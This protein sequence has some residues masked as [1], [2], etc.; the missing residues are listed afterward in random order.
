MPKAPRSSLS[1]SAL[2]VLFAASCGEQGAEPRSAGASRDRA[3]LEGLWLGEAEIGQ[4]GL[5]V[6]FR[7]GH[8][9][10][11]GEVASLGGVSIDSAPVRLGGE[12]WQSKIT[13][14]E[15]GQ[16]GLSFGLGERRG[17]SLIGFTTEPQLVAFPQVEGGKAETIVV[18]HHA[19]LCVHVRQSAWDEAMP[20]PAV[21]A[22]FGWRLE[23]VPMMD[24]LPLT[25]G[26]TMIM[27]IRFDG[28]GLEGCDCKAWLHGDGTAK[29]REV[30]RGKSG[31]Q[32]IIEL[33]LERHGLWRIVA[34]HRVEGDT[35]RP[36]ELHI[37]SLVFRTGGGR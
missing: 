14:G 7:S 1:I 36:A 20:S 16:L 15:H 26:E 9:L 5:F 21:A 32:G 18:Q 24:P 3:A 19:K 31:R 6:P 29:P 33:P 11:G 34:R 27:R 30:F 23:V 35:D 2:L 22:R 12:Q 8:G 17:S 13:K 4:D 10:P 25:S 28:P 37:A